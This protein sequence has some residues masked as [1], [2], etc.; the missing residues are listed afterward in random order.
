M[1]NDLAT[2]GFNQV[3]ESTLSIM[4]EVLGE[5]RLS[6]AERKYSKR[7]RKPGTIARLAKADPSGKKN[8]YVMWAARQAAE[9]DTEEDIIKAM[10]AFDKNVRRLK[11]RD[12]NQYT[13]AS[14]ILLVTQSL[15]KTKGTKRREIKQSRKDVD[16]VYEDGKWLAIHP[17]NKRSSQS[18]G[19]KTNWCVAARGGSNY[20]CQYSGAGNIFLY[21]FINKAAAKKVTMVQRGDNQ[22]PDNP[23]AKL[24]VSMPKVKK[25]RSNKNQFWLGNDDEIREPEFLRI[26]PKKIWDAANAHFDSKNQT[27]A[28]KGLKNLKDKHWTKWSDKDWE[29]FLDSVAVLSWTES[30][31]ILDKILND[32]RLTS[33]RLENIWFAIYPDGIGGLDDHRLLNTYEEYLERHP[34]I[35]D[36]IMEALPSNQ[37]WE[38]SRSSDQKTLLKVINGPYGLT[39][40]L[41]MN[42]NL[43]SKAISLVWDK[44]DKDYIEGHARD[45]FT[46]K[47]TPT[48]VLSGIADGLIANE[49]RKG[50]EI[51]NSLEPL[52]R[53]PNL[54][55]KLFDKLYKFMPEK[56]EGHRLLTKAELSADFEDTLAR[57]NASKHPNYDDEAKK[58]LKTMLKFG[59]LTTEQ[60][61]KVIS[62]PGAHSVFRNVLSDLL[63]RR[64]AAKDDVMDL[65]LT[66]DQIRRMYANGKYKQSWFFLRHHKNA[67]TDIDP[68]GEAVDDQRIPLKTEATTT[69]NIATFMTP[70]GP[71][72]SR[73]PLRYQGYEHGAKQP[74]LCK[75]CKKHGYICP[76]C[77]PVKKKA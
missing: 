2:L 76:E 22:Q 69:A 7:I 28:S 48:E 74:N 6:D 18:W 68:I 36:K 33:K 13:K 60:L 64:D 59:R 25:V 43:G 51:R 75:K 61:E 52:I 14:E 26:V 21:Y 42:T 29:G 10:V 39:K 3:S 4:E 38:A 57:V 49:D 77:R 62:S 71:P 11:Q 12:I 53:H 63:Y 50:Y 54:D 16:V 70:L 73:S 27:P 40:E 35:T 55:K 45:Y 31:W 1:K 37:A 47:N 44:M 65:P 20:F 34:N 24:A 8:K 32:G 15:T 58:K 19:D 46:N 17:H 41:L 66:T 23:K 30:T 5:S 56:L 9:G 72:M 67:P